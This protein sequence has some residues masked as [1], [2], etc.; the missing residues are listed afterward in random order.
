[1]VVYAHTD[2][3]RNKKISNTWKIPDFMLDKD[4][5]FG[6]TLMKFLVMKDATIINMDRT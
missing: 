6:T 3:Q 5:E 2:I 4:V 1:M